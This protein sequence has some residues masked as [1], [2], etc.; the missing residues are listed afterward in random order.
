MGTWVSKDS[1]KSYYGKTVTSSGGKIVPVS[2]GGSSSSGGT[3]STSSGSSGGGGSSSPAPTS[4]GTAYYDKS[5]GGV[6][7]STGRFYPT[8]NQNW[9]PS[10]YES[11]TPPPTASVPKTLSPVEVTAKSAAMKFGRSEDLAKKLSPGEVALSLNRRLTPELKEEIESGF[12]EAGFT[13]EVGRG[14]YTRDPYYRE[15]VTVKQVTPKAPAVAEQLTTKTAFIEKPAE[16]AG[17]SRRDDVFQLQPTTQP[18]SVQEKLP[19][20]DFG[21][22]ARE[23]RAEMLMGFT[24]STPAKLARLEAERKRNEQTQ[25]ILDAITYPTMPVSPETGRVLPGAESRAMV[26]RQKHQDFLLEQRSRS[27]QSGNVDAVLA[28]DRMYTDPEIRDRIIEQDTKAAKEIR[29]K[30]QSLQEATK[31]AETGLGQSPAIFTAKF[32]K[33]VQEREDV[34]R[35]LNPLVETINRGV[36]SGFGITQTQLDDYNKLK[37]RYDKEDADVESLRSDY[38]KYIS[39]I[40]KEQDKFASDENYYKLLIGKAG[41]LQKEQKKLEAEK[42]EIEGF[43]TKVG[44]IPVVGLLAKP[45]ESASKGVMFEDYSADVVDYTKRL[46]PI[47]MLAEGKDIRKDPEYMTPLQQF[48]QDPEA[49]KKRKMAEIAKGEA[50]EI[51][52]AERWLGARTGS[53]ERMYETMIKP[54]YNIEV[55]IRDAK[56]LGDKKKVLAGRYL[57]GFMGT[58]TAPI[59]VGGVVLVGGAIAQAAPALTQAAAL[60]LGATPATAVS[61]MGTAQ[62][63]MTGTALAIGG[64]QLTSRVAAA[65]PGEKAG[66]ALEYAGAATPIIALGVGSQVLNKAFWQLTTRRGYVDSQAFGNLRETQTIRGEKG[67]SDVGFKV[68]GIQRQEVIFSKLTGKP[69]SFGRRYQLAG[70]TKGTMVRDGG[71]GEGY[72]NVL[73]KARIQEPKGF[74]RIKGYKDIYTGQFTSRIYSSQVFAL[75]PPHGVFSGGTGGT[76]TM[77]VTDQKVPTTIS[78]FEAWTSGLEKGQVSIMEG[79]RGTQAVTVK[80]AST[81]TIVAKSETFL[82]SDKMVPAGMRDTG[83]VV[84]DYPKGNLPGVPTYSKFIGQY[85]PEPGVTFKFAPVIQTAKVETINLGKGKVLEIPGKVTGRGFQLVGKTMEPFKSVRDALDRYGFSGENKMPVTL[86]KDTMTIKEVGSMRKGDYTIKEY[87]GEGDITITDTSITPSEFATKFQV[88]KRGDVAFRQDIP[89]PTTPPSPP[90][91]AR[92]S[93]ARE[94]AKGTF[95]DKLKS[96]LQSLGASKKAQMRLPSLP[97]SFK[98]IGATALSGGFGTS[99]SAGAMAVQRGAESG[100]LGYPQ[101]QFGT[102]ASDYIGL[103][104]GELTLTDIATKRELESMARPQVSGME[105]EATAVGVGLFGKLQLGRPEL[106]TMPFAT[107]LETEQTGV[108]E[109]TA[110]AEQLMPLETT[111][112]VELSRTMEAQL[113][114][115]LERTA[116]AEKTSTVSETRI[117]DFTVP[118]AIPVILPS[119]RPPTIFPPTWNMNFALRE[120]KGRGRGSRAGRRKYQYTPD[121]MAIVKKQY[122]K[123][124]PTMR[125]YSGEE[126]RL[127]YIPPGMKQSRRTQPKRTWW[128]NGKKAAPKKSK[129]AKQMMSGF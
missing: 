57:R 67:A 40:I 129:L 86:I 58:A 72:Y 15:D 95:S 106:L 73:W 2:G 105:S 65:K 120:S 26:Q 44:K 31:K 1:T 25:D 125:I 38:E 11:V 49:F 85:F 36:E 75:E 55:G 60:K 78:R 64:L 23:K 101:G 21:K 87:V 99:T 45:Y 109:R 84:V 10:G 66:A 96:N 127:I 6:V 68:G 77:T 107:T 102:M 20:T 100:A 19:A 28:T 8:S 121:L 3:T 14:V 110:L 82:L 52:P 112:L 47:T 90:S 9:T 53:P 46:A 7:T 111:R 18:V 80:G 76:G 48:E 103:Q 59:E 12:A 113:T 61:A 56:E 89:P 92:S 93:I 116:L 71:A 51:A 50:M 41:E 16:R 24:E 63:V 69:I 27:I 22:E 62:T 124:R 115:P 32:S 42:K 43:K 126:R 122:T 30:I 17:M 33:E 79:V 114:T 34:L 39:P 108:F 91:T 123:R 13:K 119:Y 70:V 5:R 88:T 54:K 29:P 118:P 74:F 35:E 81:P 97:Q 4:K 98:P 104:R 83:L 94:V 117:I 128:Q 37:A